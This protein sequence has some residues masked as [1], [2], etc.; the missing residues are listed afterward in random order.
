MSKKRSRKATKK[1]KKAPTELTFKAFFAQRVNLGLN[2][3]FEE[4]A[5]W[6]FFKAQGLRE[7]EDLD[8]YLTVLK[9]Y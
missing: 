9:K 2:R 6:G 1:V 3:E 5:I 4:S 8:T 7:K